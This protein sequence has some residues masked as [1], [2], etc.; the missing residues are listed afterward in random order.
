MSVRIGTRQWATVLQRQ[1]HVWYHFSTLNLIVQIL[2]DALWGL[3]IHDEHGQSY[4]GMVPRVLMNSVQIG[5]STHARASHDYVPG[6]EIGQWA[7]GGP[8]VFLWGLGLLPYKDTWMTTSATPLN[9]RAPVTKT[10]DTVSERAPLLHT[11]AAIVAGGPVAFGDCVG[12]PLAAN[13]Q[14][15]VLLPPQP[16]LKVEC[17]SCFGGPFLTGLFSGAGYIQ[18][19]H[20]ASARAAG[21]HSAQDGR[22]RSVG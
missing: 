19:C 16:Y 18:L 8:S 2:I 13:R 9:R 20:A 21:W 15:P 1:G 4:C 7:V 12:G 3:P 10:I 5:S 11:I 6:Q 14:D 22:T 17:S